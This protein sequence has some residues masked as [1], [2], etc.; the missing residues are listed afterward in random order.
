MFEADTHCKL[1]PTADDLKAD[2][3]DLGQSVR[4]LARQMGVDLS[5]IRNLPGN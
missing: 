2:L 5:D 1:N 4:A 3:T